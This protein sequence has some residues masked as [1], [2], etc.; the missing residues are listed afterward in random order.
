MISLFQLSFTR[1]SLIAT[2]SP[3]VIA[4]SFPLRDTS[5]C[6]FFHFVM[7]SILCSRCQG[8]V[9][10]IEGRGGS[11][12]KGR[13][14]LANFCFLHIH[15]TFCHLVTELMEVLRKEINVN[16][17][18]FILF[19]TPVEVLGWKDQIHNDEDSAY[20]LPVM[21]RKRRQSMNHPILDTDES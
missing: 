3:A 16:D 10:K 17:V 21:A 12:P 11:P 19:L 2:F 1:G 13:L 15:T 4:F 20:H 6:F 8:L 9:S 14:G 7:C 18:V 5:A